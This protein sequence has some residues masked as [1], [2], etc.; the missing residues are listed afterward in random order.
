MPIPLPMVVVLAL[1]HIEV[2][3]YVDILGMRSCLDRRTS[4]IDI[5]VLSVEA[6]ICKKRSRWASLWK[7]CLL[8]SNQVRHKTGCTATKDG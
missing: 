2:G 3:L 1:I 8:V 4:N 5:A 6:Q 7:N